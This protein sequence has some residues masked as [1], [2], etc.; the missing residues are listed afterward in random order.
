MRTHD[1]DTLLLRVTAPTAAGQVWLYCE[2]IADGSSVITPAL[3]T[4]S[5]TAAGPSEPIA[6]PLPAGELMAASARAES[7][8]AGAAGIGLAIVL[9]RRGA[10]GDIRESAL[11][12]GRTNGRS[13]ITW[14]QGAVNSP[15]QLSTVTA[16]NPI[17]A[18]PS[19][20][21]YTVPSG[22]AARVAGFVASASIASGSTVSVVRMTYAYGGLL[23]AATCSTQPLTRPSSPTIL[24]AVA[25]LFFPQSASIVV[26]PGIQS[27]AES[28]TT[29][30]VEIFPAD[31]ADTLSLTAL[32]IEFW[33]EG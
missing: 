9:R 27:F 30:A 17:Q 21:E 16:V 5:I 4:A 3:Y 10:G 13:W 6:I 22:I 12:T 2:H 29:I 14:T 33:A 15:Q 19:R 23:V 32:G 31:P 11:A 18:S 8:Q 25:S 1:A 26:V 24:S 7:L 20:V 28:G